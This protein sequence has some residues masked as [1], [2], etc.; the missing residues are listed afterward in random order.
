MADDLHYEIQQARDA[1]ATLASSKTVDVALAGRYLEAAIAS[2]D[3]TARREWDS[4]F[5]FWR[6]IIQ[7]GWR[8]PACGGAMQYGES[9]G[10]RC[11]TW[12]CVW[13]PGRR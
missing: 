3:G 11:K 13:T 9:S 1:L 8:C 10:V 5:A 2:K 12:Q 6:T 7:G 4:L